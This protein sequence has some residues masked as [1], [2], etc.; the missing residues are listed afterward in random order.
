LFIAMFL[1]YLYHSNITF[2]S[3]TKKNCHFSFFLWYSI[4]GSVFWALSQVIHI[5][6]RV[7]Y[8]LAIGIAV[9]PLSFINYK[10]NKYIIF[11]R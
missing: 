6:V 10:I 2:F 5:F 8:L 3:S 9:M 11:D 1:L 4:S 7:H